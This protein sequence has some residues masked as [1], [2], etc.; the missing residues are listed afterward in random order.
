MIPV[1]IVTVLIL[2]FIPST[3]F[4]QTLVINEIMARPS[5]NTEWVE[6]YNPTSQSVDL[7]GW[8]IKDGNNLT[9]DDLTLTGQIG[10]LGYITFDHNKGWLNDSGSETVT[11]L[12]NSGNAVDSYSYKGATQGKTYGRQ[13][14]GGT[15]TNSLDPTKGSS[16]GDI[17]PTPTPTS[18]HSPLPTLTPSPTSTPTT[19][20]SI[21]KAKS[22]PT[23]TKSPTPQ[24]TQSP[25]ASFPTNKP[26]NASKPKNYDRL[27]YHSATVAAV[28]ASA[29]P[30]AIA[31]VKSE[32]QLNLIPWIGVILVICGVGSLIYIYLR[33]GK[34][35]EILHNLFRK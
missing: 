1:I 11:L 28:T 24:P 2:L 26:T 9:S 35:H 10:T 33:Q 6:I 25:S 16:N 23:A 29:T 17:T 30:S 3:T 7:T 12:D 19:G 8:K 4:A 34:I 13:P 32:K 20:S 14:D 22:S 5:E 21:S 15:W 18:T 27:V 31:D